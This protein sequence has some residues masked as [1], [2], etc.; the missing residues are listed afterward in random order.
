MTTPPSYPESCSAPENAVLLLGVKADD[1]ITLGLGLK[2]LVARGHLALIDRES[3][4]RFFRPTRV[5][6]LAW[7]PTHGL[8]GNAVLDAIL[9]EFLI[10]TP[11]TRGPHLDAI[12]AEVLR[13]RRAAGPDPAIGVPYEMT[14]PIRP[15]LRVRVEEGV[16]GVS[17]LD[18][19]AK[20]F[21]RYR[22]SG[23]NLGGTFGFTQKS[24][25]PH[26]VDR[27]LSYHEGGRTARGNAA[28][29]E[30]IERLAIVH[31]RYRPPPLAPPE[32]RV[33]RA[34]EN[35][36]RDLAVDPSHVDAAFAAIDERVKEG[37]NDV[38]TGP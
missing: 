28:E 32:P 37:W 3:P 33:T 8:S 7:G 29:V 30:L 27:G 31:G 15:E 16:V 1:R 22:H 18:L 38:Y 14:K 34:L 17:V 25:L 6:L 9:R 21:H 35:G 11:P 4:R 12:D 20:I 19:A 5:H 23:L 24:V 36:L 10:A 26:L 13:W 2:E